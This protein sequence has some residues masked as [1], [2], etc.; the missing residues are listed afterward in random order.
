MAHKLKV[1]KDSSKRKPPFLRARQKM[2][3][4]MDRIWKDFFEKNPDIKEE[5]VRQR[6]EKRLRMKRK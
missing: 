1:G 5:D 6:I 3:E 4:Q 2:K